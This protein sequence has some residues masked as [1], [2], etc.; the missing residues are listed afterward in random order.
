LPRKPYDPLAVIPS[1]DAIR[2]RLTETLTLAERLRI[3]LEVAESVRPHPITTADR[4]PTPT[5][6]AKGA[7]PKKTAVTSAVTS[8]HDGLLA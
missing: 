1:P 8:R 7:V 5:T 3:L 6:E 2:Q 4:L